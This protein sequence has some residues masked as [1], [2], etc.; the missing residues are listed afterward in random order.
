[1]SQLEKRK[2]RLLLTTSSTVR[3]GRRHKAIM[4]ELKPEFAYVWLSGSRSKLIISYQS[5]YERAAWLKVRNEQL[6]KARAKK[7]AKEGKRR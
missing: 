5:I 7:A 2:S 1:M 6:E 4:L 3:H